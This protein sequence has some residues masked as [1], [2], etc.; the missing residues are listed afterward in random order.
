MS[1]FGTPQRAVS[2]WLKGCDADILIRE[3]GERTTI[4]EHDAFLDRSNEES[5]VVYVVHRSALAVAEMFHVTVEGPLA[6][7]QRCNLAADL[8][9]V[10][11]ESCPTE[12][13]ECEA[14]IHSSQA[15]PPAAASTAPI[16]SEPA[17]SRELR[18][19][20]TTPPSKKPARASSPTPITA[21]PW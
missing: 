2:P 16:P 12:T 8:A 17:S 9:T 18:Q 13:S 3:E 6:A 10:V 15:R 21:R 19:V 7:E 4:A 1:A 14:H 20:E 11:E 5:C